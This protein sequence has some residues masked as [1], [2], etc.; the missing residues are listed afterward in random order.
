MATSEYTP[1]QAAAATGL[2]LAA[3]HK[4]IDTRLVKPRIS[5]GGTKRRLLTKE[6]LLFLQLQ[7]DGVR[8]LPLQSRRE[9]ARAIE[10]SPQVDAVQVG[11]AQALVVEVK[12]ARRKL[13]TALARLARAER[14]ANRDPEIMSGAPV[15]RGTRI[16]IH[17]VADMLAQG[18]SVE[19][20][21]E[22]YPSL[23]RTKVELAPL[24]VRAFPQR[25]R[26]PH[27]PRAKGQATGRMT[28]DRLN[29][30]H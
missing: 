11:N 18:A 16:P 27:R 7:A 9:L 6:Q 24:Y 4:A 28:T 14:I 3:V 2:S 22:G 19:E 30:L 23:D 5:K 15:Y 12:T 21:L 20:I 1:A 13:A 26:P 8:L 10:R 29:R 25:G 17:L